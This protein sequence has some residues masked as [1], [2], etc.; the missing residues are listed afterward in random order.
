MAATLGLPVVAVVG[1]RYA[2]ESPQGHRRGPVFSN[3][4]GSVVAVTAVVAA[5]V[6]GASLDNLVSH[7]VRYG[8]NWDVLMQ[9]EGGYGNWSNT[10]MATLIGEQQGVTGWSTFSF[11]QVPIDGQLVPA[12]GLATHLGS[13]EPPTVSGRP[14]ESADDIELGA[15]TLRQ[16]HKHL[17]DTVKVGVGST[18]RQMRVVGVV[19]LPSIGVLLTDHVSLGHG[20]MLPQNTLLAVSRSIS[21]VPALPSTLAFDLAPGTPVQ[22]VV[23]RIAAANPD[24]TPGGTY[25]VQRVLGA[26]ILNVAQMGDQPL[27]LAVALAI[28][29]IISLAATIV[30]SARQRR[31]ELATLKALGLTRGQLRAIISWQ[32]STILVI[33]VVL[34]LP[35][36][37]GAG[38]LAWIGFA[39]SLGVVPALTV[40]TTAL[41]LGLVGLLAAGNALTALAPVVTARAPTAALLRQE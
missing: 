41:V 12:L 29:V 13:V 20:A 24:G 14:I 33:A 8:W 22:P 6:F 37:V 35:L 39:R 38:R 36:G 19:T 31:R 28:A 26:Q 1:A 2:V 9:S 21:D 7:P 30:G 34:G 4:V 11:A 23:Y 10:T 18:A 16:L 32:T 27:V 15:N 17:G 3:L 5:V 25:Q 40:P